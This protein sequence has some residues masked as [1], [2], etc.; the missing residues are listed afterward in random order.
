MTTSVTSTGTPTSLRFVDFHHF[1]NNSDPISCSQ[2]FGTNWCVAWPLHH[3][4]A[5]EKNKLSGFFV[6]PD[7]GQW[8]E[9]T[10][11]MFMFHLS[12]F[13]SILLRN[14]SM[15][16]TIT[17]THSQWPSNTDTLFWLFQIF[18]RILRSLNLP[19]GTSQMIVPRYANNAYDI[20]H[21]VL[22]V[23]SLL[24]SLFVFVLNYFY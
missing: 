9:V 19:V 3:C 4:W 10:C 5:S 21:V 16:L 14:T 13:K 8:S 15:H 24:V 17:I 12:Y 20:G 11:I 1:S 23:S 18:T 7:L 22:W 2:I 6:D